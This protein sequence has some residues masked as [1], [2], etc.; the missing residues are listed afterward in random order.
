[1]KINF[2]WPQKENNQ[3]HPWYR[4]LLTLVS[5]PFVYIGVWL[6]T[7]GIFISRGPKWAKDFWEHWDEF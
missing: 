2:K 3:L 4:I 6:T 5:L 1:M 7:F